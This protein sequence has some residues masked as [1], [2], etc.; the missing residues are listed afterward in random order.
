MS[1]WGPLLSRVECAEK[2][3]IM[4]SLVLIVG[5]LAV[6]KV[7]YQEY[8]E[9]SALTEVLLNTY[10]QDAVEACEREASNRNIAVAYSAWTTPSD[11]RISIGRSSEGEPYWDLGRAVLGAAG[12]DPYVV[13]V[14]RERPYRIACDYDIVRQHATVN[15]M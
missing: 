1:R 12:R 7:G 2:V 13:I 8:V 14:A 11:M 15:R 10:R 9:R 5:L 3:W 6:G 4:R